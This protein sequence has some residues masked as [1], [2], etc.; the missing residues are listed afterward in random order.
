MSVDHAWAMFVYATRDMQSAREV[1]AKAEATLLQKK[2]ELEEA[3]QQ[4]AA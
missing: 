1:L 2:R 4:E 3:I